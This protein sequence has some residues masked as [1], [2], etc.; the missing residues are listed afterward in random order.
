MTF[1]EEV[2]HYGHD[3]FRVD[4]GAG[5]DG[6]PEVVPLSEANIVSSRIKEGCSN[7]GQHTVA[8]DVDIPAWLVPSSTPGHSHLYIDAPMSWPV[9]VRLLDALE[10]AGVIESGYNRAAQERG[11][12]ALRPPWIKKEK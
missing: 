12:T 5:Y 9:Y 4:F 11:F 3:T 8:I 7:A 1:R 10:A 6:S 2:S